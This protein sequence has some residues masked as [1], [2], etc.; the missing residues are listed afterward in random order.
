VKE[1][2]L[3]SLDAMR[4]IIIISDQEETDEKSKTH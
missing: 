3:H 1:S 4:A 2:R